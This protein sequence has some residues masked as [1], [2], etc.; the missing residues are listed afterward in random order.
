M[1]IVVFKPR[2]GIDAEQRVRDWIDFAKRN[3]P[4]GPQFDWDQNEW[5]I[6]HAVD[7]R[8]PGN[9]HSRVH[10]SS[11]RDKTGNR[12]NKQEFLR[13]PFLDFAKAVISETHR[14]KKLKDYKKFE[15]ALRALEDALVESGDASVS[16]ATAIVFDEA[17]N[18]LR[19]LG[20]PWAVGK[21][22]ESIAELLDRKQ[23]VVA[24]LQ[25]RSPFKYVKPGRSD[26]VQTDDDWR[27]SKL[28]DIRSILAL[29]DIN[30]RS[31]SLIDRAVTAWVT[32]ALYAPSRCA[33]VLS[34]FGPDRIDFT[35]QVPTQNVVAK[36]DGLDL[37]LFQLACGKQV[38]VKLAVEVPLS[39]RGLC[40]RKASN[41]RGR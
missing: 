19:R 36:L 15:I 16:G 30:H 41:Q 22:L 24:P 38:Q 35:Q 25:W 28:P 14:L 17:A 27:S 10:F 3:Q 5:E 7:R 32:L 26:Y 18:R 31:Q 20:E 39:K 1:T 4:F 29:A 21:K 34:L 12:R 37:K 11:L 2:A 13:P 6:T 9:R 33:E 8:A 23:L 40:T